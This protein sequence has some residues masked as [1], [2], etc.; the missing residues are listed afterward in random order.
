VAGSLDEQLSRLSKQL[1]EVPYLLQVCSGS[2]GP[3]DIVPFASPLGA[4][5]SF[6]PPC[7]QRGSKRK[8]QLT[9]DPGFFHEKPTHAAAR[10][11][12]GSRRLT[13]PP[14]PAVLECKRASRGRHIQ[15]STLQGALNSRL[16]LV[17]KMGGTNGHLYLADELDRSGR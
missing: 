9:G 8:R 11:R 7:S 4:P 5:L 6:A 1:M 13:R 12:I 14:T 3:A 17:R 10:T 15:T 16:A 2:Q